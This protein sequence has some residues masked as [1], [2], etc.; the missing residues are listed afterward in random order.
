M[1][2]MDRRIDGQSD[3]SSSLNSRCWVIT[4]VG[5]E[6]EEQVYHLFQLA[7]LSDFKDPGPFSS[8]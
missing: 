1:D 5:E 4:S 3:K 7:T 8:G 2:P 6:V